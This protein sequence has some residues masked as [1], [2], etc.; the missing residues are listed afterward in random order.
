[1]VVPG[2]DP[3]VKAGRG[4][5]KKSRRSHRV[6]GVH[7]PLFDIQARFLLQTRGMLDAGPLPPLIIDQARGSLDADGHMGAL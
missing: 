5:G 7:T 3:E 2:D 6:F 4:K 1:M